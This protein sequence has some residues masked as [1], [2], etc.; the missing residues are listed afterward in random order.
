MDTTM[1]HNLIIVLSNRLNATDTL[2]IKIKKHVDRDVAREIAAFPIT[3][4]SELAPNWIRLVPNETNT[5]L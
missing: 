1:A 3:G 4:M 5:G 2:K